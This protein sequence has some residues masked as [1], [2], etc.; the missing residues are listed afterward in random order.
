MN[1]Y[2]FS[3]LM[4]EHGEQNVRKLISNILETDKVD[5]IKFYNLNDWS[6]VYFYSVYF[7]TA[8][9]YLGIE[10]DKINFCLDLVIAPGWNELFDFEKVLKIQKDNVPKIEELVEKEIK[11]HHI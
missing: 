9:K 1:N 4:Q 2:Y 7:A 11:K 10:K 8:L 3:Y 6:F 5:E